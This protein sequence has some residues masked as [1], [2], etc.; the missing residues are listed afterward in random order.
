MTPMTPRITYGQ[1]YEKLREL[2]FTQHEIE[3]D[4]KLA[5]VFQHKTIANAMIV[6]PYRDRNEQVVPFHMNS[7]LATLR[8]HHLVPECNPLAT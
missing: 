6:L 3:V 8:T 2:G 1:M 7:V 4:G 5:D